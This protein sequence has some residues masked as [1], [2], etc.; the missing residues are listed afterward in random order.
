MYVEV[1]PE[2]DEMQAYITQCDFFDEDEAAI[3]QQ[4]YVPTP[5]YCWRNGP[6]QNSV[7]HLGDLTPAQLKMIG[8]GVGMGVTSTTDLELEQRICALEERYLAL[9]LEV[10]RLYL[11][12]E[13]QQ[14][15]F[16]KLFDPSNPAHPL[17][18]SKC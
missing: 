13:T 11:P 10:Q 15:M 5:P 4:H 17:R 9:L 7:L 14:L 1:M 12:P 8:L 18:Y 3:L 6:V 2:D 16:F